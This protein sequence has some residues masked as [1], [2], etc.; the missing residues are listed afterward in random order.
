[1]P[2]AFDLETV[3]T[4]GAIQETADR[5]DAPTRAAFLKRAAIGTGGLVAG[6]ALLSPGTAMARSDKLDYRILNFALTLEY[7]EAEFYKQAVD[8]GKLSG[9]VLAFAK[10]VGGHEKTH[11]SALRGALKRAKQNPVAKPSFD[12]GDTVTDQ[13]K[14]LETSYVLENEG[15]QAYLGQAGRIKSGAYLAVAASIVTIEARHAA[16]VATLLNRTPFSGSFSVTPSGAFDRG[17]NR[18]SV[19]RDVK[20]TGFI[21]G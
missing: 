1:M 17:K 11:V 10:L 18:S 7:L 13:T 9:D 4:D 15:V 2:H 5:V 21:T 20:K 12:F 6:G 14:F 16:A 8:N 3:D 19:Q